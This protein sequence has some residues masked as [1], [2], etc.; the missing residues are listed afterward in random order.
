MEDKRAKNILIV[1]MACPQEQNCEKT[2]RTKLD[3]YK[4]IA[5][6]TREKRPG[7]RV[8]VVPVI[9]GCLGGN[10]R[11]VKDAIGR[12]ISEPQEIES[13]ARKMQVSVLL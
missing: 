8:E 13:V 6:E 7:Y 2:T 4:Q 11:K 5:F 3:K 12:V 9:I 1:D 10:M